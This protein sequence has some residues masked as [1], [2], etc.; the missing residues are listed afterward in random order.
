MS[1]RIINNHYPEKT[2]VKKFLDYEGVKYLWSKINMNDYPNNETLMNVIEAIDEAKADKS[3]LFSGS[4]NDLEDKPFGEVKVN[5]FTVTI[6]SNEM[7]SSNI[8][9]Y[10]LPLYEGINTYNC[11][12]ADNN[13]NLGTAIMTVTGWPYAGG[14]RLGLYVNIKHNEFELDGYCNMD[15]KQL[16]DFNILQNPGFGIGYQIY[17][18]SEDLNIIKD[19]TISMDEKYI[20]NTIARVSNIPSIQIVTWEADD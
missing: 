10:D 11:I 5:Y 18:Y 20:P 13:S 19:K 7:A 16:V 9:I 1:E 14:N 17:I 3:E 2:N 8:N 15:E 12:I 6:N 4:W